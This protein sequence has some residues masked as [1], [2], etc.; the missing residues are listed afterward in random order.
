YINPSVQ[1]SQH[2][3]G[4]LLYAVERVLKLSVPTLYVWLCMFIVSSTCGMT[5]SSNLA[6]YSPFLVCAYPCVLQD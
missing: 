4:G 5:S 2:L 3:K 6:S 1:D